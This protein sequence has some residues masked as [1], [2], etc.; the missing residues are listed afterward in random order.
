MREASE[1]SAVKYRK[2]GMGVCRAEGSYPKLGI[3]KRNHTNGR[4][5][6]P[7]PGCACASRVS[8][9]NTHALRGST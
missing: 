4:G 7:A 2:I 9:R 6:A 1:E 3:L 5:S 8:P